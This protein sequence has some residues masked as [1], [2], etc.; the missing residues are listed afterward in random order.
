MKKK[1]LSLAA[2]L[3]AAQAQ[4]AN[5][6]SIFEKAASDLDVSSDALTALVDETDSEIARLTAI[7]NTAE[8][9]ALK[10]SVSAQNVRALF[11]S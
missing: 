2:R 5:A 4:Q 1:P 7:R 10:A 8:D 11:A 3:S 9:D 6:L